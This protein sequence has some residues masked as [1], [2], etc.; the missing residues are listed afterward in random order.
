MK[1]GDEKI[2]E[3]LTASGFTDKAATIY[4]Y[5]LSIG[6]AFPSKIALDTKLNRST[7][8]KILTELSIQGLVSEI[9]KGKKLYYQAERPSKLLRHM[10]RKVAQAEDQYENVKTFYPALEGLFN[11]LP[12]KP[13][14][15]YF[16]GVEGVMSVY[17]DHVSEKKAY[18]MVGFADTKRIQDFLPES[19]FKKYR[20]T[21]QHLK[22][23][24]R[25]ILPAGDDY[26]SYSSKTYADLDAPFKPVL[27]FI[28]TET[29]PFRGEI[30][31]YGD[32]KVSVIN[33]ESNQPTAFIIEDPAFHRMMRTM[34]ELSWKGISVS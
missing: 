18:E 11:T 17:D 16:E 29:F 9:E 12:T 14:I 19:Y 30:T 8:Y 13:K 5:L 27:K 20:Q 34:F 24:T 1:E 23:T 15:S 2:K 25:G 6:G 4:S 7:V 22:I 26:Q 31:I 33:L 10:E 3:G 28:P 32:R 21:K